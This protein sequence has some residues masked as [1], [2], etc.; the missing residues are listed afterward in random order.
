MRNALNVLSALMVLM[1]IPASSWAQS[2]NDRAEDLCTDMIEQQ[3]RV[4]RFRDVESEKVGNHKWDVHGLVR[5]N[6]HNYA[7]NCKIKHGQVTSYSYAG[8]HRVKHDDD[9]AETAIAVGAGIALLAAIAA[10]SGDDDSSKERGI[11]KSVMEDHCHDMI[12]YRVRDEQDYTAEVTMGR[13]SVEGKNLV[14]RAR[15]DYAKGRPH[16]AAAAD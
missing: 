6:S 4:D 10:T 7:F 1:L 2:R 5:E 3:Y 16:K 15:I 12:Q 11:D 9:D 8:P 14:G 13:S